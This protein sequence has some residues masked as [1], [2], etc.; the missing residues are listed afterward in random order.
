MPTGCN[1]G[2][3][4]IELHAV[5]L[6]GLRELVKTCEVLAGVDGASASLGVFCFLLLVFPPLVGSKTIFNFIDVPIT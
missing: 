6:V 3:L 2:R 4:L 5:G 1:L